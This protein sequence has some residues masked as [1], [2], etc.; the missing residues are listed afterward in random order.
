MRSLCEKVGLTH[1]VAD[2]DPTLAE[3]IGQ[4]GIVLADALSHGGLHMLAL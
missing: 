4:P 1:E 2:A 3:V